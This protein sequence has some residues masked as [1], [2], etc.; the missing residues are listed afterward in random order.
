VAEPIEKLLYSRKDAASVLSISVRSVDYLI[1]MGKL[2]TRR[3][4]RKQLIP[5]GDIRRFARSDHPERIRA[6]QKA[7]E[8]ERHYGTGS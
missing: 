2:S 6:G 5:S 1:S 8:E 3:I 4:G 7:Q